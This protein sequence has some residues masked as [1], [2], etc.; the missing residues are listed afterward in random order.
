[1]GKRTGLL[2]G[3]RISIMAFLMTGCG[4]GVRNEVQDELSGGRDT[5]AVTL[6]SAGSGT[7]LPGD[8][9]DE[10]TDAERIAEVCRDI[11]VQAAQSGTLGSIETIGRMVDRLGE[12]GY[13][14]ASGDNQVDMAGAGRCWSSSGR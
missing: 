9:Q 7:G 12:N 13:V 1:M 3:I 4:D 6:E 5:E 11:Y 14:A 8:G 2:W 10:G